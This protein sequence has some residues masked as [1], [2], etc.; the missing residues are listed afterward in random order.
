MFLAHMHFTGLIRFFLQ[1]KY[2]LLYLPSASQKCAGC[3]WLWKCIKWQMKE[4]LE[5]EE[6]TGV[7]RSAGHFQLSCALP[8]QLELPNCFVSASYLW[9]VNI[10][11]VNSVTF[12]KHV[13]KALGLLMVISMLSRQVKR[14]KSVLN[15]PLKHT[16]IFDLGLYLYRTSDVI[17]W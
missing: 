4:I 12:V 16:A 15:M 3:I 7:R 8:V 1:S 17:C 10:T 9:N 14:S 11:E 2:M 13:G 5:A 6:Q